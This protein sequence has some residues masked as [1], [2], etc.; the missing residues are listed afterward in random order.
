MRR[1]LFRSYL[2]SKRT[3]THLSHAIEDEC[4]ASVERPVA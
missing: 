1:A 2:L 4:S 3:P